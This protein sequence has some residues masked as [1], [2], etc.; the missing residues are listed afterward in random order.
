VQNPEFRV[1]RVQ[2]LQLGA[3]NDIGVAA[4]RIQQRRR[5]RAAAGR[6]LSQH[7][8]QRHDAGAAAYQEQRA[9]ERFAPD[10]IAADWSAHFDAVADAR[11]TGEI[12]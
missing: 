5:R 6:A 7:R 11:F 8:H 10:E 4:R 9:L 1:G 2:P 3:I 12:G